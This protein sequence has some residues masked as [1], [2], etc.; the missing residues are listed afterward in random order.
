MA[1][2]DA[3]L[4]SYVLSPSEVSIQERFLFPARS[5]GGQAPLICEPSLDSAL[6]L[7]TPDETKAL[8]QQLTDPRRPYLLH[9]GPLRKARFSTDVAATTA[10]QQ[11][12][13]VL[14]IKQGASATDIIKGYFHATLLRR[15]AERQ[16]GGHPGL[17]PADTAG[18]LVDALFPK[19]LD[20][21]GQ[22]GWS[23]EHHFLAEDN[24]RVSIGPQA[25]T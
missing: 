13:V 3:A 9:C 1:L 23:L 25:P 20:S 21:L 22:K 19:F 7:L 5:D 17:L 6:R 12:S 15:V 16:E 18:D 11:I 24:A 14:W 8:Y 2:D 4:D 10:G